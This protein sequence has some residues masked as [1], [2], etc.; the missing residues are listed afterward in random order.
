[1][2][3]ELKARE[4]W[5]KVCIHIALYILADSI[6]L[7]IKGH[8]LASLQKVCAL[9]AAPPSRA[10]PGMSLCNSSKQFCAWESI[11]TSSSSS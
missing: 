7:L 2:I 9:K 4:K 3:R 5:K 6:E 1:M 10:V 11:N 8:T